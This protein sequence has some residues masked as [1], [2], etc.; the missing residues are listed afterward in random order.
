MMQVGS[1]TLAIVSSLTLVAC[2]APQAVGPSA[3]LQQSD[4][5]IDANA[6]VRQAAP[7]TIEGD[8]RPA[9]EVA[10]APQR[11]AVREPDS[12][13]PAP[14]PE[15]ARTRVNVPPPPEQREPIP[16][17][18]QPPAEVDPPRS[19]AGDLSPD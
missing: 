13:L 18:E 12:R 9:G 7:G 5:A 17:P 2:G 6:S 15:L 1:P 10:V 11:P 8:N 19:D 16:A 14:P 4:K 3:N